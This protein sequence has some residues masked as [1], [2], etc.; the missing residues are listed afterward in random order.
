MCNIGNIIIA[1]DIVGSNIIVISAAISLDVAVAVVSFLAAVALVGAWHIINI[2]KIVIYENIASV[3]RVALGL[4][5]R[6]APA[7]VAASA[8]RTTAELDDRPRRCWR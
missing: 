2:S 3:Q 4:L 1:I 8:P 5:Q 7:A 6:V